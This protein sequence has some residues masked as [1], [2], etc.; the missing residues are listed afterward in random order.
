MDN[1]LTNI[2]TVDDL[3]HLIH[4][5]DSLKRH[6]FETK[7]ITQDLIGMFLTKEN[8]LEF[9]KDLENN[10]INIQDPG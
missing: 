10:K 8:E 5:L 9:N 2:H 4:Q 7:N 3:G 6:I 1:L